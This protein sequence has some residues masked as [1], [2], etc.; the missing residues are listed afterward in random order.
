MAIAVRNQRSLTRRQWL[1]RSA[2]TLALAGVGGLTKPYLS[3]A[4]DRPKIAGGLQASDESNGAAVARARTDRPARMHV[5]FATVE[6]F[7]TI[8]G[9]VSVDALP[10]R[11][12]TAKA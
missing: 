1:V 4:A 10:D 5:E 7:K 6:S 2:S 3:R 8:I 9:A 12:L 11:D